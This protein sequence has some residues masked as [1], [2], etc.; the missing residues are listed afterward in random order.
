[1]VQNIIYICVPIL[2]TLRHQA[3]QQEL[4]AVVAAS[5]FHS[6]EYLL[7]YINDHSTLYI[8]KQ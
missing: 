3:S 7:Y 8:N 5:V 6:V 4:V 1:M 2:A